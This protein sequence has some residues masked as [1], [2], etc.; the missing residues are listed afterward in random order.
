MMKNKK[1]IIATFIFIFIIGEISLGY[2]YFQRENNISSGWVRFLRKI[3]AKLNLSLLSFSHNARFTI[4]HKEEFFPGKKENINFFIAGFG[5]KN[6]TD[7]MYGYRPHP[8]VNYS[9]AHGPYVKSVDYF[10]YRNS[11]D[12]Y[13]DSNRK[14]KL[15][16]LTG[17]SEAMGFTHNLSIA[18]LIEKQ[19]NNHY[20][21]QKTEKVQEFKVLNLAVNSYAIADEISTYVHLAYNSKPEFVISHSGYNDFAQS[22]YVPKQFSEELGLNFLFY[23]YCWSLR[24]VNLENCPKN[25]LF[26]ETNPDANDNKILNAYKKN[27]KKFKTIVETNGG[28]FITGLQGH[29]IPLSDQHRKHVRERYDLILDSADK[30]FDI[31]FMNF[32]EIKYDDNVHTNYEDGAKIIAKAYADLIIAKLKTD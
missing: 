7:Q 8:Y 26:Y 18:E 21:N 16:V 15:I 17:G 9:N 1:L 11:R 3:E 25:M 28:I 12:L 27:I 4:F 22:G 20:K 30:I 32:K 6:M 13:F 24:L 23:M 5:K 2:L 19:L 14:Y 10:G 29:M 31:N